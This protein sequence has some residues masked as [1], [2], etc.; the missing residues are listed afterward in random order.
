MLIDAERFGGGLDPDAVVWRAVSDDGRVWAVKWT[1]RDNRFGLRLARS[2]AEAATPG[3]PEP[4]LSRSGRPWAAVDGGLLSI[5]PWVDGREAYDTGLSAGE[6]LALGEL[7]RRIHEHDPGRGLSRAAVDR[8]A[9]RRGIRRAGTHV[10]RRLSEV[11]GLVAAARA[12]VE[13]GSADPAVRAFVAGWPAVRARIRALR[14]SASRLKRD[15]SPAVRV[16][17][18]GDPHLGNVVVDD[19]GQPW[20]IDFDDAV[21]A[22]KEVDLL[23]VDPGVL[24]VHRPSAAD[25]EAFARGYGDTE[26][27]EDRVLRFGCVRAIEDLVETAHELLAG[28]ERPASAV[29]ASA[30]PASAAPASPVTAS[31]ADLLA[32]FDGILSPDG[33][34]GIVERRLAERP[35]GEPASGSLEIERP[36]RAPRTRIANDA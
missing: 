3:V 17:C 18:H 29:T 7:L 14:R 25:L 20:L 32:L 22:P 28:E 27:D 6:W 34:A 10:K 30:A 1:R 15:R 24:F 11:D 4:R 13:S 2:L 19:A 35:R 8:G 36:E 26:V 9:P 16:S 12:E 23:L 21:R 33:L 31:S 5:T